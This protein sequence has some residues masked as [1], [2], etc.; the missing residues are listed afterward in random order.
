MM[1]KAIPTVLLLTACA[2][3]SDEILTDA[4]EV[5]EVSTADTVEARDPSI[6]KRLSELDELVGRGLI[7]EEEYQ[8]ARRN[9]LGI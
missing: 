7:S 5:N 1:K 2:S 3:N 9:V 8:E 6:S 4:M